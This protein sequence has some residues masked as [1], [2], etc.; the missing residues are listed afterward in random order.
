MSI[1]V[2]GELYACRAT[3]EESSGFLD[4]VYGKCCVRKRSLSVCA[5]D[6]LPTDEEN[7]LFKIFI[8]IITHILCVFVIFL[9]IRQCK[10]NIKKKSI[11]FL[12]TLIRKKCILRTMYNVKTLTIV[13]I[14]RKLWN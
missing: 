8:D 13:K 6:V 11:L 14:Y 2:T 7:V 12:W 10:N 3:G 1:N 4:T 5:L 9:Y